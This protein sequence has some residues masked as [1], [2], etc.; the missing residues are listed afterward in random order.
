MVGQNELNK[1]PGKTKYSDIQMVLHNGYFF[2]YFYFIYFILLKKID[3][4]DTIY[5]M[6]QV[7]KFII[8]S[9]NLHV[10]VSITLRCICLTNNIYEYHTVQ[11]PKQ[12]FSN[13]I[14]I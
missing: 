13:V 10:L 3:I 9:F 8:F 11:A 14:I 12:C 7:L 1:F 4:F 6:T 2:T 5:E